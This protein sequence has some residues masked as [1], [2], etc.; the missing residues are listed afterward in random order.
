MKNKYLRLKALLLAGTIAVTS[1]GLSGCS[2]DKYEGMEL[3]TSSSQTYDKKV[4]GVGEHIIS[5]P[6][7]NPTSGVNQYNYH[8]GYKV[9]GIASANFSYS[10]AGACILY[11]NEYPVECYSTGTDK[12]GNSLYESFGDPIDFSRE[13]ANK[14]GNTRDFGVGE[15][16]LSVEIKNP[17]SDPKQYEYHEGYEIAGIATAYYGYSFG[18]ACILYVNTEPVR[19]TVS[20]KSG[21]KESYLTFG[22]PIEKGKVKVLEAD[23]QE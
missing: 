7:K 14:T 16:I 21:N 3:R 5:V 13:E 10:Y 20:G 9:A 18:G 23:S 8:P 11:E 22:T 19:C 17:T 1:A 15:H 4:F 6:I 12:N 2:S